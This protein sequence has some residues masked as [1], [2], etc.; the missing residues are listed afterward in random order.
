MSEEN[1]SK[2]NHKDDL[3]R[4]VIVLFVLFAAIMFYV[5]FGQQFMVY[6]LRYFTH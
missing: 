2:S 3:R 5:V 4:L 1:K 6:I